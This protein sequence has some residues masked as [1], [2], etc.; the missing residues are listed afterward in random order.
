[1]PAFVTNHRSHL[2][3]SLTENHRPPLAACPSRGKTE[4]RGGWDLPKI[5]QRVMSEGALRWQSPN[6]RDTSILM[7]HKQEEEMGTG[8]EE[9]PTGLGP[10]G[11]GGRREG[12]KYLCSHLNVNQVWLERGV[13]RHRG[14]RRKREPNGKEEAEMGVVRGRGRKSEGKSRTARRCWE[15]A[16]RGQPQ[17]PRIQ[18]NQS[19]WGEVHE[20][21][22]R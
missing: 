19:G 14:E 6:A 21:C 17:R 15:W 3:G 2:K 9:L 4:A 18:S 16:T 7:P 1:M 22:G 11:L 12:A 10:L 8:Q 13:Q 5:T 20:E